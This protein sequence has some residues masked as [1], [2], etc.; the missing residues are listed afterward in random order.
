MNVVA[1]TRSP[2]TGF[3]DSDSIINL[4]E[5]S[6]SKARLVSC[7]QLKPLRKSTVGN[8]LPTLSIELISNQC[9]TMISIIPVWQGQ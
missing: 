2:H 3:L 4:M 8:I 6:P 7:D 9:W 5:G 1:L